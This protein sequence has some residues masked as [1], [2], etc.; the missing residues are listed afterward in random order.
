MNS[1]NHTGAIAGTLRTAFG[2][3]VSGINVSL[4][5]DG[6]MVDRPDN[7]QSSSQRNLSKTSVDYI[8]D[9]LAPGHYIVMAEYFEGGDYN[10]S[11]TV[12][13]SSEPMRAD[14]LLSNIWSRPYGFPDVTFT[15]TVGKLLA[16]PSLTPAA[17]E[18]SNTSESVQ[19]PALS[20]I[21]VLAIFIILVM[22]EKWIKRF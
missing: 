8:F 17:R 11:V 10:D 12:D 3:E 16:S 21:I 9:H 14:I 2:Y 15:P 22:Y 4:W 20:G 19:S 7:P 13:V 18:A 5:Q 1:T 6:K